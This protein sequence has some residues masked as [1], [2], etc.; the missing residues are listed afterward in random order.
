MPAYKVSFLEI[1]CPNCGEFRHA[2]KKRL[3]PAEE[4]VSKMREDA[5]TCRET[6]A[7]LET[8]IQD[9]ANAQSAEGGNVA[10]VTFDDAT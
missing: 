2:S 6:I 10:V 1:H 8:R 5:K 4:L 7:W 9:D 3:A